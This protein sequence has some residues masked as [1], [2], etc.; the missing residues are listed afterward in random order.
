MNELLLTTAPLIGW[1]GLLA[2]IGA[3]HRVRYRR[4]GGI[5]FLRIGRFQM[6]FCKCREG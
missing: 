2:G 4:V 3:A 6:T 1:I 5:R